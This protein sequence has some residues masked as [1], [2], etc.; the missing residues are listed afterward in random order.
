MH[1]QLPDPKDL[2]NGHYPHLPKVAIDDPRLIGI[3]VW[4]LSKGIPPLTR[5]YTPKSVGPH[6][7]ARFMPTEIHWERPHAETVKVDAV[8]MYNFPHITLVELKQAFGIGNPN[9]LEM[10]PGPQ[11]V[12]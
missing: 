7:P 9:I 6:V 12:K 10:Y 5:F 11:D 3:L 2:S 8:L 4:L 1:E